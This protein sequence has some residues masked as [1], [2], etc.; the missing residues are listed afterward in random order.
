MIKLVEVDYLFGIHAYYFNRSICF[1]KENEFSAFGSLNEKELLDLFLSRVS[2]F[3]YLECCLIKYNNC[4]VAQ[5]TI[6]LLIM[7]DE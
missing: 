3:Q 2:F 6:D 1:E 5:P 7:N 4:L